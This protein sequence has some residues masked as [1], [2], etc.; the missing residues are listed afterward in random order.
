MYRS[1]NRYIKLKS[2][3]LNS[4]VFNVLN[5]Q[6][7]GPFSTDVFASF[8]NTHLEHNFSWKPDPQAAGCWPFPTIGHPPD[9]ESLRELHLLVGQNHLT[10]ATR[11]VS[12]VRDFRMTSGLSPQRRGTVFSMLIW[13]YC[14][15][16][17]HMIWI[18]MEKMVQLVS[19][20]EISWSFSSHYLQHYRIATC[21][22]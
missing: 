20:K 1:N 21:T 12:S 18:S 17:N 19:C 13:F 16:Q 7:L 4:H 6:L 3:R 2:I 14:A 10:L 9:H 15:Q 5:Q 22:I 8:Q 11:L